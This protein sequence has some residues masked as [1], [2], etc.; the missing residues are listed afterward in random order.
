MEA[1]EQNTEYL[2]KIEELEKTVIEHSTSFD[3]LMTS[4]QLPFLSQDPGA[5]CERLSNTSRMQLRIS[6]LFEAEAA[7]VTQ[8][9]VA[10][11]DSSLD[12][13]VTNS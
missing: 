6:Q 5:G 13:S 3:S 11:T 8:K 12:G 4:L 2:K 7:L 1:K 10:E 9:R